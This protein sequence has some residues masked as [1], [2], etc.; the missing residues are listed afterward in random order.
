MIIEALDQVNGFIK[1][2]AKALKVT[3]MSVYRWINE[4]PELKEAHEQIREGM[5]DFAES[6][7]LKN[8]SSGKETSLIFFLKTQ[9]KSRGYIESPLVVEPSKNFP[10]TVV[11]RTAQ[12][13]DEERE[14]D[15]AQ[16]R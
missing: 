5:I 2:A 13:D 1:P 16:S 3:R 10:T 8:I 4:D 12:E 15:K 6:Q 9:G 14:P 11:F 7:L